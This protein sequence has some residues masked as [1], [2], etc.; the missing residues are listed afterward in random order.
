MPQI[1]WENRARKKRQSVLDAI[2]KP[3]RLSP[4]TIS[5]FG[6]HR[7]LTQAPRSLMSKDELIITESSAVA[8]LE[9]MHA[10]VWSAVTVTSA[11]C[12]RAAIAH[13][14]VNCLTEILFNEALAQAEE[15][16]NFRAAGGLKGPLHGLPMSFMDRYRVANT[17]TAAG[18][19]AWLG[20]K[21][22]A[23]S[24]SLLVQQLRSLGVI[25]FCKT[26]LPMSMM[27]GETT[28]N[29]MGSTI[30]PFVRTL[31]SGGAAGGAKD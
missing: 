18:Y 9:N 20:N 26:N 1:A 16:D 3:W 11:F 21:E 6:E 15:L 7:N 22:T 31:S 8:I 17:E 12:H 24:E 19:I 5:A 13:Q 23:Q 28:N 4:S 14:L 2:P 27:L 30:N 10:G 29:I 25:P